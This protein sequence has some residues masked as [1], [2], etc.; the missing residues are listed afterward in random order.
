VAVHRWNR[1]GLEWLV[2]LLGETSNQHAIE[3]QREALSDG[4]SV[5]T[6]G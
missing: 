1:E 2:G 3:P 4:P 6:A 5:S